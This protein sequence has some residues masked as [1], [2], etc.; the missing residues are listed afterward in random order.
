MSRAPQF[1]G[2]AFPDKSGTERPEASARRFGYHWAVWRNREKHE[3]KAL[4]TLTLAMRLRSTCAARLLLL[5]L[6]ASPPP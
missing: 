3:T 5:S 6:L 4:S 1:V 2:K